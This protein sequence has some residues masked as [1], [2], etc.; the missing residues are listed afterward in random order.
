MDTIR[1]T[2]DGRE[3]TGKAGD[4]ILNI[5]MQN[6]I[7]IPN[8]CYNSELKVYGACGLC[9]VEAENVPKLLRACSAIA[10]DGMVIHTDSP[11]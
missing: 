6:G 7:E 3:I 2:I 9:V 11:A 8:L 1:I 5:A 4:S 10:T